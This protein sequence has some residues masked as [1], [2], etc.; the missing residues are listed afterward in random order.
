[1]ESHEWMKEIF[2]EQFTAT[3]L[4]LKVLK[5]PQNWKS[6][7]IYRRTEFFTHSP[8]FLSTQKNLIRNFKT[9]FNSSYSKNKLKKQHDKILTTYPF[10]ETIVMHAHMWTCFV[11]SSKHKT[12]FFSF[13]SHFPIHFLM[14]YANNTWFAS[15]H[16]ICFI[17]FLYLRARENEKTTRRGKTGFAFF[18]HFFYCPYKL[19]FFF[20]MYG[21]VKALST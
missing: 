21:G 15:N 9:N 7:E 14:V 18:S 20:S 5:K 17:S 6:T 12:T 2:I 11:S 13:S 8:F 1:M 19:F 10:H 3:F 16:H 4:I